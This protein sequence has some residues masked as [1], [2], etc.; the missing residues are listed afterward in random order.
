MISITT[1][2]TL[3]SY[4]VYV[5]NPD[6]VMKFHTTRLYL[7]VPFVV[8]GIYRYLFLT[9]TKGKGENPAEVLFSDLPFAINGVLWV[10]VFIVV[11]AYLR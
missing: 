9:Y 3:I 1:A 5:A 4:I 7:T 2:T 11:V 8:F 10:A 6:I